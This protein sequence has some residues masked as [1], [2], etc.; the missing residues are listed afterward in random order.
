M[1]ELNA[2]VYVFRC[3]PL[4][5]CLGKLKCDNAQGEYY[6]TDVPAL[7]LQQGG[8]VDACAACTP[9]EMLGVNTPQQLKEVEDT[10]MG[11]EN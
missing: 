7:L 9:R 10:L 4:L 3:Q 8:K 11:K 2:G 6:L 1:R 5:D